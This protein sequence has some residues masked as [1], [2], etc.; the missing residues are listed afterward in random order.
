MKKFVLILALCVLSVMSFSQQLITGPGYYTIG[1][2]DFKQVAGTRYFTIQQD[3]FNAYDIQEWSLDIFWLGVDSTG[4]ATVEV[5][6]TNRSE[7]DI[8]AQYNAFTPTSVTGSVGSGKYEDKILNWPFMRVKLDPGNITQG[9][10]YVIFIV[11][12]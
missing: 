9:R 11:E 10:L 3:P 4:T 7:D 6:S 2:V 12:D 5:N 8:W 1:A